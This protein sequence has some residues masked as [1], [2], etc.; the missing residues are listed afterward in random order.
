M[1]GT[2][3]TLVDLGGVGD[4]TGPPWGPLARFG[5]F[6]TFLT[7]SHLAM[8]TSLKLSLGVVYGHS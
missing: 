8:E 2:H 6:F 3:F 7:Y 4:T 1:G 5:P